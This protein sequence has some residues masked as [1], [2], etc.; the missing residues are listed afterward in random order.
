[1]LAA[2]QMFVQWYLRS[3]WL[4]QI[5]ILGVSNSIYCTAFFKPTTLQWLEWSRL[6]PPLPRLSWLRITSACTAGSRPT[7][8]TFKFI[9]TPHA[10]IAIMGRHIYLSPYHFHF[11]LCSNNEYLTLYLLASSFMTELSHSLLHNLLY[12]CIVISLV[13]SNHLWC[14]SNIAFLI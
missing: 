7:C 13:V 9:L 14:L 3:A 5:G 12:K 2:R 11:S 1:M 10:S 6:R 4:E 8:L